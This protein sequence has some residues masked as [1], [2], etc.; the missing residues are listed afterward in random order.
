MPSPEEL[1]RP[2]IDLC[3]QVVGRG[4]RRISYDVDPETEMFRPEYVDVY[5]IPFSVIPFRGRKGTDPEPDDK[6]ITHVRALS[7][8]AAMEIKFPNVEGYVLE[9]QKNIVRCNMSKV[10]PLAIQVMRNPN[11]VFVQ[12]QVGIREGAPGTIGF[13]L[14]QQDRDEY[15]A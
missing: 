5:G 10:E 4:L 12:P 11:Q 13:E 2:N 3:E 6:P 14:I 8:R 1:A 15:Y 7:N 9:L